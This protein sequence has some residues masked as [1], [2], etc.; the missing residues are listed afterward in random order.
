MKVQERSLVLLWVV[1]HAWL[2]SSLALL[3][4]PVGY[5]PHGSS[6][7]STADLAHV[8]RVLGTGFLFSLVSAIWP[9]T[10]LIIP[11]SLPELSCSLSSWCTESMTR[12][13][14]NSQEELAQWPISPILQNKLWNPSYCFITF[15]RKIKLCFK[16]KLECF[17][18]K[19]E[20]KRKD[21]SLG[22]KV[23][24]DMHSGMNCQHQCLWSK[25]GH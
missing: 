12:D 19:A 3:L 22:V 18:I 10:T 7:I 2:V 5:L 4:S 9:L 25:S 20:K 24:S 8:N 16:K 17:G 1:S 21:C 23:H 6:V 14:R 13:D 15:H 11:S